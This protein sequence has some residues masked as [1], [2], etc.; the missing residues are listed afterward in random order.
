[1]RQVETE[2]LYAPLPM[3]FYLLPEMEQ[4]AHLG[5]VRSYQKGAQISRLGECEM[6]LIFV[7]SGKLHV[8]RCLPN[9]QEH[10]V[11]AAG[12]YSLLGRLFPMDY[13]DIYIVAVED[14]RLCFFNQAQVAALFHAN[15]SIIFEIIKNY[16]VKVS[17]YMAKLT[18]VYTLSPRTRVI[19][20]LWD[21]YRTQD[22][23]AGTAPGVIDFKLS[24]QDMAKIT[25]AHYVT[26]SRLLKELKQAG[27]LTKT[28]D[29]VLIHDPQRLE[30][31]ALHGLE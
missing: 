30:H 6:A 12:R 10:F 26:V 18:E 17:Y 15:E 28:R 31:L 20:M 7:L 5:S 19:R 14:A 9:G 1:M 27:I 25:G 4:Y 3:D 23:Q 16:Y 8:M 22:G 21:M 29:K 13:D 11:Y 2:K 24:Q